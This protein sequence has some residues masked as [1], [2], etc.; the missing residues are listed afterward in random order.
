MVDLIT[1]DSYYKFT[2]KRELDRDLRSCFRLQGVLPLCL[3]ALEIFEVRYAHDFVEITRVRQLFGIFYVG[4]D[5]NEKTLERKLARRRF[6]EFGVG[7]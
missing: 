7:S 1:E 4:L 5:E 2:M 3:K 6:E